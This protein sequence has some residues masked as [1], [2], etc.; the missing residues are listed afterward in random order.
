[1]NNKKILLT[2]ASGFLGTHILESLNTTSHEVQCIDSQ[3]LDLSKLG[4]LK[5]ISTD[6]DT[7]IHL[8]TWTRAGSFCKEN[9]GNQWMVNEIINLNVLDL[10]SRSDK[11]CHLISFGTSVAYGDGL[12]IKDEA[13]YLEK[14]PIFD[15]YGYST[16]KRS[17]L[18]GQI[19]INKQ[20]NKFYS[21]L[22]PSTIY[23]PGYHLDGRNLHFIYDII[24]KIIRLKHFGDEVVLWGDGLQV[25]ELIYVADV[26]DVLNQTINKPLNTYLNIA[27]G[28]GVTIKEFAREVC[29]ILD[30]KANQISYDT[31]AFVGA[32]TKVLSTRK[33]DL[34]FPNRLVTNLQTGLK[35]TISWMEPLVL[36]GKI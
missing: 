15:Y 12:N 18:Y 30:I 22:I 9:I 11:K 13:A 2:G 5:N 29:N 1:M 33:L 28:S 21:H 35:K 8:A 19:C 7:I 27:S 14:D 31:N 25:R 16:T 23:G 34:S 26:V 36:S 3:T 10:W 4:S 6:F 17:L 32:R 20:K 24:R